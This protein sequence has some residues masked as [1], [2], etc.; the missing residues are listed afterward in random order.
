VATL[1]PLTA[2]EPVAAAPVVSPAAAEPCPCTD[3]SVN[4]AMGCTAVML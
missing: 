1:L 2:L 4:L 3:G